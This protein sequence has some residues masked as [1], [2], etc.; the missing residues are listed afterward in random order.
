MAFV[1]KIKKKAKF[2]NDHHRWRC[3]NHLWGDNAKSNPTTN[4]TQRAADIT[5]QFETLYARAKAENEESQKPVAMTI[6]MTSCS[7]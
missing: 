2:E 5:E 1:L 6:M 3:R 4:Q 7:R